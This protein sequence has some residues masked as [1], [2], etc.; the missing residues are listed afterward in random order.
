MWVQAEPI[1]TATTRAAMRRGRLA[2]KSAAKAPDGSGTGDQS[3]GRAD[4]RARGV[5]S[6]G[7]Q[8]GATGAHGHATSTVTCGEPGQAAWPAI[9]AS[10]EIA[11]WGS[12]NRCALVPIAVS[13]R[14]TVL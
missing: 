3:S 1:R 7:D 11:G 12:V 8:R 9:F 4:R 13:A 2:A 10:C 6:D 5:R 14:T